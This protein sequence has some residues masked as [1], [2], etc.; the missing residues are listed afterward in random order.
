MLK[1]SAFADVICTHG[2]ELPSQRLLPQTEAGGACAQPWCRTWPHS[3]SLPSVARLL[4]VDELRLESHRH[5]SREALAEALQ[6][7]ELVPG[8]LPRGS[9]AC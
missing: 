2:G 4:G 3:V 6:R 8:S 9:T 1:L 7:T 5:D